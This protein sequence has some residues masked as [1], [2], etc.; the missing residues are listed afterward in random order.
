MSVVDTVKIESECPLG[1]VTINK[2]DFDSSKHK[3]FNKSTDKPVSKPV[4][5]NEGAASKEKPTRK[6]R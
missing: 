3:E 2:S 5:A 6:G 4:G 1:Y